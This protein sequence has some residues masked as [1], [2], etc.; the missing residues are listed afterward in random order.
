V[1]LTG[2][3][4]DEWLTGSYLGAGDLLRQGKLLT[5]GRRLRNDFGASGFPDGLDMA[6]R[7]GLWPL[8]PQPLRQLIRRGLG[9]HRFPSWLNPDFA[10]IIHLRDRIQLEPDRSR[11]PSLAQADLALTIRSGWWAHMFEIEDRA[12]SWFSLEERHPFADRR[13]AEFAVSLPEDQRWRGP[14]RKHLLRQAMQGILPETVRQRT[15]K[16]EFSTVFLQTLRSLGQSQIFD[17]LQTANRGWIDGEK[18]QRAY[19]K[20]EAEANHHPDS[21]PSGLWPFWMV[22]GIELWLRQAMLEQDRSSKESSLRWEP[23]PQ[24]V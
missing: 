14:Q 24:P 10:K 6:L 20:M 8:L 19:A 17:S 12:A 18:I 16:A 3:G 7:Y 13:L 21:A 9:R 1:L 23:A 5:L 11:Y 15:T 22:V 2:T 4:G